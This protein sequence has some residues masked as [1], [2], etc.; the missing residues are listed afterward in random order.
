MCKLKALFL[1]IGLLLFFVVWAEAKST[2]SMLYIDTIYIS[3]NQRTKPGIIL[4]ELDFSIGDSLPLPGL[5]ACLERN[6]RY[7]M[8]TG[9]FNEVV[10]NVQDWQIPSNRLGISIRVEEAWYFY[11]IPLFELADRNF[12]VWWND[13]QRDFRRVNYG[14]AFRHENLSGR[15]DYFKLLMQLGF[16][17]KLELKYELPFF[18]RKQRWGLGIYLF[19]SD[20]KYLRYNTLGNME[21]F[22][23]YPD[24]PLLHRFRWQLQLQRRPALFSLQRLALGFSRTSIA[25]VVFNELNPHFLGE[26]RS[27]QRYLFLRYVFTWDGRDVRPYPRRGLY[28]QFAVEKLGFGIFDELQAAYAHLKVKHYLPLL[29]R[30]G[31]ETILRWRVALQRTYQPYYNSRALGY[32]DDFLRGYEYYLI[33]GLDM[34]FAKWSLRLPLLERHWQWGRAMPVAGLRQMPLRLFLSFNADL[35]YV[36]NPYYAEGNPL[37]N[38]WLWSSG[39]GLD[40]VTYYDKV[41]QIQLSRNGLGEIG[42]FLH[43]DF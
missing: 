37:S 31:L 13:F 6:R 33:D 38:S 14:L 18:D 32:E 12:N 39:I 30:A 8:N 17:R 40:I 42:L 11:A 28:F 21:R 24:R 5:Q 1:S 15:R 23:Y 3:G 36:N 35:G 4:R 29:E 41:V 10:L 34:A 27:L 7:L 25:D 2:A 26:G 19:L 20:S 9:L 22:A 43:W 16:T